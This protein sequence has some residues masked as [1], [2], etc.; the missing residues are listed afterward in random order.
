MSIP[1]AEL[2]NVNPEDYD[3][4]YCYYHITLDKRK[5]GRSLKNNQRMVQ[6]KK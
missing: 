6:K 4:G 1:T 3:C 2:L 5:I